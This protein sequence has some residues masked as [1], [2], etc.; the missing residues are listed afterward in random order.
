MSGN[1]ENR[2]ETEGERGA[3]AVIAA[4]FANLG[5]AVMKFVGFAF[6]GSGA[7]LAEAVHSTADTGNQLL[8]L[9]G[10]R[11]ARR[12]ADQEHQ[13]GYGRERYFWAFVV[14]LMLFSVGSL[15]SIYDGIQKL[16]DPHK[17]ESAGWAIAI[18]FGATVLESLS[19]RTAMKEARHLRRG[20]SWW[21]F[22]RTAKNPELPIVMLEDLA[23]LTGLAFALIAVVTADRTGDSKYDAIGSL[24]IGVL[25]GIVAIVLAIEMR[26]LLLGESASPHVQEQITAAIER[27]DDVERL[28]HLRTE[29]RGPD[30][31]LVVAK[32]EFASHLTI[33]ELADVVDAVEANVRHDVP[34]AHLIY[35]E[36]DVV[37]R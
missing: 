2:G 25:L 11:K 30:E 13:F 36:P 20:G 15:F 9:F 1:A 31:L 23:A 16:V 5:I 7:M 3:T 22:I 21:R 12:S 34:E 4:F 18:L 33:R 27:S 10:G 26:S 14:A 32:I 37:R 35:L 6:T 28:I 24:A 17:L 19:F 29:H 8:L